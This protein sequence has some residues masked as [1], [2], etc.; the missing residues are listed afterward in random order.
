MAKNPQKSI[1]KPVEKESKVSIKTKITENS[2]EMS[3]E[4]GSKIYVSRGP[5]QKC[6][7]VSCETKMGQ[8]RAKMQ[9]NRVFWAIFPVKI[10]VKNNF[11][12]SS[13]LNFDLEKILLSPLKI[14]PDLF[15]KKS[16]KI[17]WFHT[18]FINFLFCC[19][20]FIDFHPKY[21]V[22]DRKIPKKLSFFIKIR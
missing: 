12:I 22:F 1:V 10:G 4:N 20:F 9:K 19:G 8:N 2:G 5:I 3:G 16:N 7:C 18:F 11:S 13:H 21:C 6:E 14:K 17:N 15:R